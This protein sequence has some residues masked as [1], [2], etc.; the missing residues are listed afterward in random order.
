M[1]RHNRKGHPLSGHRMDKAESGRTEGRPFAAFSRKGRIIL[2]IPPQGKSSGRKLHPDLVMSSGLQMNAEEGNASVLP[3][4]S[5]RLPGQSLRNT[6]Q[7]LPG[8]LRIFRLRMGLIHNPRDIVL[9]VFPQVIHKGAASVHR[10]STY[11]RKIG[12]LHPAILDL[13]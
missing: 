9:P 4:L 6:L 13:L 2:H 1:T 10:F 5:G 8:K 3:S 7:K 11:R 12:L